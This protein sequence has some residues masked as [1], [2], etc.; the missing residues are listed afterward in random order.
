M[1][2]FYKCE[3]LLLVLRKDYRTKAFENRVVRRIYG[4]SEEI[5]GGW[6]K[7]RKELNNM[8]QNKEGESGMWHAWKIREMRVV[9][10]YGV[11]YHNFPRKYGAH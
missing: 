2:T 10:N 7:D 9:C 3:T 6:P 11:I 5:T 8:Y 4:F 1:P